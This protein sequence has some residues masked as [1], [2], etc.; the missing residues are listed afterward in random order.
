LL[1]ALAVR[2]LAFLPVPVGVAETVLTFLAVALVFFFFDLLFDEGAGLL[3]LLL[4]LL[5]VAVGVVGTD[6]GTDAS[7]VNVEVVVDVVVV[8]RVVPPPMPKRPLSATVASSTR[9]SMTR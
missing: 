7:V 9:G 2:A 3:L 5:L 8:G 6:V 4:L 1:T